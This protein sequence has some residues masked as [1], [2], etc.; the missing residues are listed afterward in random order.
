[1]K[2]V[3]LVTAAT[4]AVRGGHAHKIESELF[5]AA[6][7]SLKARVNVNGTEEIIHLDTKNKGLEVKPYCWH[8][9]YDFSADAVLLCFSSV[10]YLPGDENYITDKAL[11]LKE[12]KA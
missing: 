1:V 12:S 3:Y 11:F 5:I 4:G 8:E 2:R 10:H 6:Q 9:F 7:G